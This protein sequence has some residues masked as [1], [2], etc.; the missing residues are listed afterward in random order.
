MHS[1]RL[2]LVRLK[3][4]TFA[5]FT[6][7]LL[8]KNRISQAFYLAYLTLSVPNDSLKCHSNIRRAFVRRGIC[9]QACPDL[10]ILVYWSV[11]A[12]HRHCHSTNH[13]AGLGRIAI[14]CGDNKSQL[15]L[16][17]FNGKSQIL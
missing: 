4:H 13:L 6:K 2:Y 9:N 3:E 1:S 16:T 15:C 14:L 11:H 5:Q 12:E 10:L 7:E 17:L 8:I